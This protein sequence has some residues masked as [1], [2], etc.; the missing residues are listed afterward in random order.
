MIRGQFFNGSC[1]MLNTFENLAIDSLVLFQKQISLYWQLANPV[2]EVILYSDSIKH[3]I[4][5]LAF[6]APLNT[7]TNH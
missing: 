6:S 4:Q 1:C 5:S 3:K 7:V 2:L